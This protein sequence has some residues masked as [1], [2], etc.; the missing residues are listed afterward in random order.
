[1]EAI[2]VLQVLE[3]QY[4]NNQTAAASMK[5]MESSATAY[6]ALASPT[7]TKLLAELNSQIIPELD[8]K[9]SSFVRGQS[10]MFPIVI[11]LSSTARFPLCVEG[12]AV[13]ASESGIPQAL[14]IDRSNR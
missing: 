4:G 9:W 2:S 10:P 3:N 12:C 14:A 11:G 13:P 7:R 1:M 8:P 5:R 6:T